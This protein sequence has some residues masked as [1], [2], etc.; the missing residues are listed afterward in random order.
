MSAGF[1]LA[2][3]EIPDLPVNNNNTVYSSLICKDKSTAE[4]VLLKKRSK[5]EKDNPVKVLEGLKE[6]TEKRLKAGEISKEEAERLK[7]RIDKRIEEIKEFE[8]LPLEE[9]KK[10]LISSLESRLEKKIE[11]NKLSQEKAREILQKNIEE[12]QAWDGK[13][14]PEILKRYFFRKQQQ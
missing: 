11:E 12:I 6:K 10:L 1:V 13:S 8:R 2:V 5:D 4:E 3:P 7:T 14:N 9:K